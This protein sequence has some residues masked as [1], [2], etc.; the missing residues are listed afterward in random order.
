MTTLTVLGLALLV[1][2]AVERLVEW[3]VKPF[4]ENAQETARLQILRLSVLVLAGAASYLLGIDLF[5]PMLQSIGLSPV[6]PWVTPLLTAVFVGG[7]SNFLHDIWP[8]P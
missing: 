6:A 3:L 8:A 1:A 2:G 5:A 7:G 4:L